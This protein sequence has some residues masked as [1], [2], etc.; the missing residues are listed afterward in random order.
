MTHS[1]KK[2]QKQVLKKL[3]KLSNCVYEG[4]L[5][6]KRAFLLHFEYIMLTIEVVT[7]GDGKMRICVLGATGRV[8]TDIVK[9]ALAD[10]HNVTA[11]ARIP[12]ALG[13]SHRSL[14]IV[15]G[16]AL[17]KEAIPT[18]VRGCDVI[19]SALG[20]DGG[21][22]LSKSMLYVL[23]AMQEEGLRRIVTVGT[24]GILQARFSPNLYR[25]QSNES[26]RTATRAAEDHLQ[27]FQ[28]LQASSMDWTI[29]CPTHLIDGDATY[30]YRVEA[31]VL[32]LEG[33]RISVGDTA[34]FT[35][36]QLFTSSYNKA[37]VGIAY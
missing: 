31:N 2:T 7:K 13:I 20:T 16:N 22:T 23:E 29:V 28:T 8:G 3:K 27:A 4:S 12:A 19:I 33:R 18:A 30:Q 24:A 17:H 32:P 34:H 37:R 26:R 9:R 21:N 35:Y 25:F 15:E 5:S 6:Y 10:G 14:Q 11:L 36:T 1:K